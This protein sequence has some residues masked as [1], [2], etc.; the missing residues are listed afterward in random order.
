MDRMIVSSARLDG[1][2]MRLVARDGVLRA[3]P[4]TAALYEGRLSADI[5]LDVNTP[6]PALTLNSS[7][8]D[9]QAEALLTDLTGKARLRGRGNFSAALTAEG[10]SIAAMKRSLSGPMSM[11][12]SEGAVTGFNL[13]GALRRWKQFKKGRIIAVEDTA[14]T[15]FT[16]F[17]GNP[18]ARAG[19]IRMDDLVLRAPAFRLQGEGVLADLHTD[20][21]DYRAVATVVNTAQGAGGKELAELEGLALPL[22]V[23]GSLDDPKIR[24]NWE[25]IL[26]RIAGDRQG[27]RT[28]WT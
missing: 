23:D 19:V 7:L 1:F 4:V 17:S 26:A 28:S 16:E 10:G 2:R 9:I 11:S 18:V 20:T 27:S 5:T 6:A 13:G 22:V 14:A 12:F 24:L 15:D 25:D 21:I 3:E 8:A